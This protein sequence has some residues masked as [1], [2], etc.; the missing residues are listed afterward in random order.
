MPFSLT[1]QLG[2]EGCFD[3]AYVDSD[4]VNSKNYWRELS[5]EI[6]IEICM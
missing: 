4:K 6:S 3:F 2:N 1:V 5:N